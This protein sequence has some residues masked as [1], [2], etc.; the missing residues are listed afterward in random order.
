MHTNFF[1]KLPRLPIDSSLSEI[2]STLTKSPNAVLHAPPGAGKTTRVPLALLKNIHLTEKKIIML[3][4]RRLAARTA[5]ARLASTL[6]EQVGKTIGYRVKNDTKISSE[7]KIEVVTEGV[8]TRIIQND[9]ELSAYSSIIFDEF[10][11]RSL[12]ADLGLALAIEIQEA[13]RDDLRILVMSATLDTQEI[14]TLLNNCPVI[15]S[16]GRSYPVTIKHVPMPQALA[17]RVGQNIPALLNHVVKTIQYSMTNDEGSILVFLPGAGEITRVADMLKSTSPQN[18]DI[19]P[20]YGNLPQKQ[21]DAA[22]LPAKTGRRKIVLAT[23]IAETSLTIEGIRVVIDSGLSR[24][25]RFSPATGMNRLITEP[26]SIAAATQRTGRAGRLESGVCYRLWSEVQENSFRAFASPEIK[27]TD[28]APLALELAQW[29]AYGEN[30]V[31]ALAWLDTPPASSYSQALTLLQQ[32]GALNTDFSI[33]DHGK[34]IAALPLHPRLAHMIVTAKNN[35]YGYTACTLAAILSERAQGSDLRHL[36]EQAASS[37][38]IEKTSKHLCKLLK[39]PATERIDSDVTGACLAL[40][41]PDRIGKLHAGSRTEYKLTNG[42]KAQLSEDSP[43]AATPFIVVAELNDAHAT[44]RIWR[45]AP[46][47]IIE[48]ET[49]FQKQIRTQHLVAWVNKT[50]SVATLQTEQLGELILAQQPSSTTSQEQILTA[51]LEGVRSLGLSSLPWTTD[52]LRLRER[53]TFMH[54]HPQLRNS[55]TNPYEWPDVSEKSLLSTLETWLSPYLTGMRKASDL[56]KLDLETILLASLEW[57]QQVALQKLAPT[58]FTVPS[59]STIRIDYSEPTAP[60]LPVKLQEMFG[61]PQTPTIAGGQL[62]LTIHL[63]SPAGRP[64]Q[65]TRDLISFWGNGYTSVRSEMRGRY[66]KHPW[67]E[68][69]LTAE[70][71]RKTN[72]ALKKK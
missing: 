65:V 43:L 52:A 67:P 22:I 28:L 1:E 31:H 68:H 23:S 3:E 2:V 5:A 26:V 39:I 58:H 66:P 60:T 24:S 64:L 40:A 8:L 19:A 53:L 32:L 35:G 4:P 33:T 50:A 56:R 27:E 57:A 17:T 18:V 70:P 13:L 36:V 55:A 10:H 51:M 59:G 15:S 61:A 54:T 30:G 20:L 71:T 29:G 44:S 49:L 48:I 16:E 7:T 9:P 69:P 38:A 12:H 6:G 47:D 37:P 41:Y 34:T 21:Q 45:C 62:P 63:L 46:I 11:E 42:R 72:R 25:S 14:S